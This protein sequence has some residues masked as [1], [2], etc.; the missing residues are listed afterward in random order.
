MPI[1][2]ISH[3]FGMPTPHCRGVRV[4]AVER[5]MG[6]VAA[7]LPMSR[8]RVS[9]TATG[10]IEPSFFFNGKREAAHKWV[11]REGGILPRSAV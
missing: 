4:F 5:V 2:I 8:R 6:W 9:P 11:E 10:R 1:A 3:A 7:N